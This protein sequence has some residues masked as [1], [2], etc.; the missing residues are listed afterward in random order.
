MDTKDLDGETNLKEKMV[1]PDFLDQNL[2]NLITLT[3]H[4]QCDMPNEYMDSWEGNLFSKNLRS[5][6]NANIKNMLLKGS[7]LKNTKEILGLVIYTGFNTKIMKNAKNPPIKMT[8][9]MKT[10]NL[11]LITV[12]FFQLV[13]CNLFSYAYLQFTDNNETYLK[14]YLNESHSVSWFDFVIKFFTFLV[15]YSHLIPISL[16]VAMEIV[17]LL[18]SWFIYYDNLMFDENANKPAIARTSELI[19]ELGQVEFLFSDKTGTL[20]VNKMEFKNCYIGGVIFGAPSSDINQENKSP[21][22]NDNQQND[23]NSQIYNFNY[24]NTTKNN[25]INRKKSI[26]FE[27]VYS[28]FLNELERNN[29]EKDLNFCGDER[30]SKILAVPFEKN[31]KNEGISKVENF[32]NEENSNINNFNLNNYNTKKTENLNFIDEINDQILNY[33]GIES[34]INIS[35]VELKKNIINF[36]RVCSLC[37]SAIC[38]EDD[39]G[40]SSYAC[41]SPEEIAFLNGAKN[42][43]FTFKKRTPNTIELFNSY[44]NQKEIW[45]I[46]LE[47][48]FES[49]RRRMTIVVRKQDDID[50]NV[51][52]LIKG[53]D[54]ALLPLINLEDLA[55]ISLEGNNNIII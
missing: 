53:A 48:P 25:E 28:S 19:E 12:F 30:I 55:R 1:C 40:I 20:T 16:Y 22:F 43:G 37:H 47:I 3:G 2:S 34:S 4:I 52:V 36:F 42:S 23:S 33:L 49:D 5:F 38:E 7:V 54:E 45:D 6:I 44:T 41:S 13:C 51:H 46:L 11:I 50:D 29:K 26:S 27:Q 31:I 15:A 10:M 24:I 32:Y 18:Q 35:A 39:Q 21:S 14:S 8:N 17:K 9:V